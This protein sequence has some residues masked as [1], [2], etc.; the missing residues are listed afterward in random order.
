MCAARN[1]K[2]PDNGTQSTRVQ[3]AIYFVGG[4]SGFLPQML[5]FKCNITNIVNHY[6]PRIGWIT[7]IQEY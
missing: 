5:K 4:K 2:D 6:C 1:T 3:S 7:A